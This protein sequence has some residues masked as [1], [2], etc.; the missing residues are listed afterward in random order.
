MERDVVMREVGLRDGIQ[1]ITDFVETEDKL[2]WIR[3]EADAGM[4]EIEVTSYVPPKLL[5]Q[6]ADAEAVTRESLS[7]VG[8][9]VAALIPNIKGAQRGFELGVHKLNFVMS[10]SETHNQKNVRRSRETSLE[11]FRSIVASAREIPS[12]KRPVICG[13]LATALGCSYEGKIEISEVVRWTVALLE[14]GADELI[15]PDTVGYAAPA[16]VKQVF[17]AV[18]AEAG[19]IPVAAHFHDTRGTG[20]ANLAAALETGVRHF[21]ASLGGMGGC[22]FAPGASGNIVMEDAVYMLESMGLRTGIDI[23]K[24]IGVRDV[25]TKSLPNLRLDGAISR[26]G[27]PRGFSPAT[28]S[29]AA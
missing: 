3:A 27:L 19:D 24:L 11:E 8:L 20:L 23:E 4:P 22:P 7:V 21:D 14:A 2:R 9:K 15:I 29:A 26:A 6:F 1:G 28:A 13:G 12:H 25:V 5:P 16:L 17:R 10:V 18:L